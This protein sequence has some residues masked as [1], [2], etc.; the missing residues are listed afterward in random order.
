MD[1]G[2]LFREDFSFASGCFGI[3]EAKCRVSS[4]KRRRGCEVVA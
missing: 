2:F 1:L 3:L 4:R